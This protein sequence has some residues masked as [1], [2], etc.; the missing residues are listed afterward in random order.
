[1]IT[2]GGC[3]AFHLYLSCYFA[4]V[5]IEHTSPVSVFADYLQNGSY[6]PE[7]LDLLKCKETNVCSPFSRWLGLSVHSREKHT[8][9]TVCNILFRTI[10]VQNEGMFLEL[11]RYPWWMITCS[12][13]WLTGS[14]RIHSMEH[15]GDFKGNLCNLFRY[16]G[17]NCTV[18]T[19]IG[20]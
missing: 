11:G 10:I 12:S 4:C 14:D 7:V 9:K 20:D 17:H 6:E 13:Q 1:M 16:R 8:P 3:G 15:C 18:L 19:T 2:A 5:N